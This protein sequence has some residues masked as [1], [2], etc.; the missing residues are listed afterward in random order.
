MRIS[1]AEFWSQLPSDLEDGSMAQDAPCDCSQA[2]LDLAALADGNL[3]SEDIQRLAEHIAQC[4]ACKMVLAVLISNEQPV[5]ASGLLPVQA[6]AV[7]TSALS[8]F[9]DAR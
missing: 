8:P 5:A 1:L 7:A 4:P 9:V 2:E 3:P 6:V